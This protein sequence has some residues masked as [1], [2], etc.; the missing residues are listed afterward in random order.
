MTCGKI[1]QVIR[2]I[3]DK[4][5]SYC[6]KKSDSDKPIGFTQK[7]VKPQVNKVNSK[8]NKPVNMMG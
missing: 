2:K 5:Y 3:G 1:Q 6:P 4:P 7:R 8:R